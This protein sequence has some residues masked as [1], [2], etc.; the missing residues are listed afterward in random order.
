MS[1]TAYVRS[2]SLADALAARRLHPDWLVLAGG[3]DVMVPDRGAGAPEWP[4]VVDL[5]GLPELHGVSRRGGVVR[6][7]ACTTY[8]ELLHDPVVHRDLPM[9]RAAAREVGAVQIR[10]RGT[11]GGNVV[12]S[13][14]VGDTLPALL[15]F[16]A[17]VDIGSAEAARI[18]PYETFL[19]GYRRVALGPDEILV[20]IEIPV[21]PPGAVQHWRK[22]GT[23]AA[24][25]ISKVSMAATALVERGRVARCRLAFGAVADRPIRLHDV[26][27]LLEG[28]RASDES[29]PPL[30]E[31]A[32][33][34][35][36]HPISD[37]RST[38][39][40]RRDVA[41]RLAA[42]FVA[43]LADVP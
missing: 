42:R 7:G 14:P 43:G 30:V 25:A 17:M 15:A 6:I 2:T 36:L 16:D 5:F 3:T 23:R 40:Y 22:V 41:A 9:L 12:T 11:I 8:A 35:T 34:D 21:P 27:A 20:A 24:Q 19:Q 39:D 33:R 37:V 26:E 18:V 13:S 31:R 10:E 29:L 28:R 32:V 38:A 4:G 1:T